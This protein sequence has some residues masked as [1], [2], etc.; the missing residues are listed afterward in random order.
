MILRDATAAD[1]VALAA[2]YN[3]FIATTT[4]SFEEDPVSGEEMALRI[5]EVQGAGLPWLV[6]EEAGRILGYAYAGKWKARRAYRH[7][8]E[9]SVYVAPDAQGRGLGTRLYEALF[10][11]A[12]AIGAHAVIGGVAMP[13]AASVALHEKLGMAKVAQFREVGFKFGRWIDVAYWQ[14]TL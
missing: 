4:I 10:E 13:N 9:C 6:A 12:K 14:K 7:S 2:I 11:R 5:A 1:G 3:P 8:V